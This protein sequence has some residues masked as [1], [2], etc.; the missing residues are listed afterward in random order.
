MAAE[1]R[2]N[3]I[4]MLRG[5]AALAVAIYHIQLLA[6]KNGVTNQIIVNN[7]SKNL[8]VG[9]DIFFV[10]SGFIMAK[11]VVGN[12]ISGLEFMR[13]RIIRIVPLYWLLT[14]FLF[15]SIN[16]I[17][18]VMQIS[19]YSYGQL[20]ASLFFSSDIF[21]MSVPIIDQGWTLEYEMLF[22]IL[23]S[24]CLIFTRKHNALVLT[25]IT[26]ML[27][28]LLGANQMFLEFI[29]GITVYYINRF[30]NLKE[31]LFKLIAIFAVLIFL[32]L[33]SMDY[34]SD[35]RVLI[36]GLPCALM[37]LACA[38]INLTPTNRLV[39][40]GEISYSLYLS[41]S[42]LLFWFVKGSVL[43][44]NQ[45]LQFYCLFLLIPIS[46]VVIAFFIHKFIEIP[47]TNL[48]KNYFS[49]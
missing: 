7:I 27:I 47:L 2:L 29:V 10:I 12:D 36:Y 15:F 8:Y 26:L 5:L 11:T 33:F 44:T 3:G 20:L 21:Y 32:L 40:L 9:V 14:F 24:I 48:T 23:I 38:N 49:R 6:E 34:S 16:V 28:Y 22:Y 25:G 18:N 17:S 1:T 41:Q 46:C 13:R 30:V 31:W 4:Q 39:V 43:I 35:N 37:L 19:S 42:L 45:L